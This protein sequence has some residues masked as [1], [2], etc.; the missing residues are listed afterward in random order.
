MSNLKQ[1]VTEYL[2]NRNHAEA[3]M[4]PNYT[5]KWWNEPEDGDDTP[6]DFRSVASYG[7]EDCGSEYYNVIEVRLEDSPAETLLVRIE[8]WYQP[9]NGAD[10]SDWKF[11]EPK[12]KT[13]TVYE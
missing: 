2:D 5:K 11:V 9:Y 1:I 6:F 3:L 10:Y 13:I 7:G 12:Q 4:H 8:G